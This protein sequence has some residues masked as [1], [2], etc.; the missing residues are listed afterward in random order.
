MLLPMKNLVCLAAILTLFCLIGFGCG[1]ADDRPGP[2]PVYYGVKVDVPKLDTDF[3]KA[4]PE[5]QAA[6]TQIK[7]LI[8]Y[9]QLPQA[10]AALNQ[11]ATDPTLT[12]PQKK[13]V[14]DLTDQIK[15]VIVNS[16]PHT[17]Q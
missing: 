4:N 13:V 5:V 2:T 7:Q 8:R 12:E 11:F 16:T 15:Q 10:L 1:K 9:A 3:T 14:A 6:A 17:G